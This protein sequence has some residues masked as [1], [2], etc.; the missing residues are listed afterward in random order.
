MI[1]WAKWDELDAGAGLVPSH[2]LPRR[3][4][5]RAIAPSVRSCASVGGDLLRCS[6]VSTEVL[7]VFLVRLWEAEDKTEPPVEDEGAGVKWDG[8]K[9]GG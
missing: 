5:A 1:L 9:E 3:R 8:G 4:H 2:P 6:A 7:R